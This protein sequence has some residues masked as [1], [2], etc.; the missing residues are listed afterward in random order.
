[1]SAAFADGEVKP[2]QPPSD[3]PRLDTD[4]GLM[5]AGVCMSIATMNSRSASCRLRG[6][7]SITGINRFGRDADAP[8]L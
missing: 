1:M 6:R 3:Q 2:E 8:C 7:A 5:L 4:L